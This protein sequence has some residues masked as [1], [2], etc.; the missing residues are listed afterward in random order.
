LAN[1]LPTVETDKPFHDSF[2]S[3]TATAAA[4]GDNWGIDYSVPGQ[5]TLSGI[6]G[7]KEWGLGYSS[8]H[9]YGTYTIVAKFDGL[10]GGFNGSALILWP[11]DNN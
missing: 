3:P 7:M 5:V 4:F 6:S 8:G 11:G 2:D 10:Y 9:G 1:P